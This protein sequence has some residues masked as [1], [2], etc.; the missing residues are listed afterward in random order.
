MRS[1]PSILLVFCV[2][3]AAAHFSN[4]WTRRVFK[5]ENDGITDAIKK[6]LNWE[7]IRDNL[8]DFTK[9]PHVSGTAANARVA[10]KIFNN[11]KKAGLEDVHF[12]EYEVLLSYPNYSNPNHMTI[13][14][15]D[16]SELYKS[17]GKSPVLIPDEQGAPGADIQWVAYAGHGEVIGDVVYCH[18]GR[19]Q[20][21]E[22]LKKLGIDLKGK[23]ALLR[24]AFGFRGDK[25]ANAQEAGA[26]GAILYSDPSE[27]ARDG[28][29]KAH[30]YPATEW[31][32]SEAVQRGS[33]MKLNG[34]PLTPLFPA[35]KDLYG[36]RTL[37]DS[38]AEGILPAIPVMPL[39]YSD[40]W[41]ILSRMEGQNVPV[42]W[43][44]GIN[45]TYKLGPGLKNSEKV[46]IDVKSTLEK[47]SVKNVVGYITGSKEPDRYVILGN[48]FDAWV[49]GSI[50]PTVAQRFWQKWAE[51]WSKP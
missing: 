43:Q 5:D 46:K 33:I 16:G 50:D 51:L 39:S 11:W 19:H 41:H 8:R 24:Y 47:R 7:N 3:G 13:L 38:K 26:I 48:H 28:I 2:A 40:A 35:K 22:Q 25:V 27:V 21:F 31:M 45:V 37:D 44:G 30:V 34:D 17:K 15:S 9:E 12:L 4:P 23:I 36:R 18:H 20:D 42:E 49:Y 10:Q 14:K 29:D 32:P 6:N 1:V